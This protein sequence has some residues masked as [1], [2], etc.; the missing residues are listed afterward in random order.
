MVRS[1]GQPCGGGGPIVVSALWLLPLA[2]AAAAVWP[3]LAL[4]RRVA[5]EL[6]A[7][8]SSAHALGEVGPALVALREEARRAY[9]SVENLPLH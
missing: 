2:V 3:L 6:D 8:R 9:L 4:T 7:L 5:A 1:Y